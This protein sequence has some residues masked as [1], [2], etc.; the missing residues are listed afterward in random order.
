MAKKS[1]Q[2]MSTQTDSFS[3]PVSPVPDAQFDGL[4]EEIKSLKQELSAAKS[5]LASEQKVSQKIRLSLEHARD[6]LKKCKKQLSQARKSVEAESESH[7]QTKGQL[8]E[9][10]LNIANLKNT[11]DNQNKAYKKLKKRQK[12][13]SND[14]CASIIEFQ[15]KDMEKLM[16]ENAELHKQLSRQPYFVKMCQ[17]HLKHNLTDECFTVI[18]PLSRFAR[19]RRFFAA[20][21]RAKTICAAHLVFA[22][23][24]S[25]SLK[26]GEETLAD[27]LESLLTKYVQSCYR[28][29]QLKRM[30][31]KRLQCNFVAVLSAHTQLISAMLFEPEEKAIRWV[32]DCDTNLDDFQRKMCVA[33]D[34]LSEQDERNIKFHYEQ[35]K[36]RKGMM[37]EICD[38][39]GLKHSVAFNFMQNVEFENDF[40][41]SEAELAATA[42]KERVLQRAAN[43]DVLMA[44]YIRDIG[45]RICWIQK[46]TPDYLVH[47]LKAICF[48]MQR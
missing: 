7:R 29:Q 28:A 23:F 36:R 10:L 5:K 3:P 16:R 8:R 14:D 32:Q 43:D 45:D 25:E 17:K 39:F 1:V 18:A 46:H 42:L 40:H 20:W 4:R 30:F 47:E 15:K 22:A 34:K 48:A 27:L 37:K 31:A 38:H 35:C 9:A 19:L 44:L 12:D 41:F 13:V 11:I 26:N 33:S 24:D 2:T 6:D 21:H